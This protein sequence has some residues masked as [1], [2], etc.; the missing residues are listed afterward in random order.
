M[1]EINKKNLLICTKVY[2]WLNKVYNGRIQCTVKPLLKNVTATLKPSYNQIEHCNIKTPHYPSVKAFHSV[3]KKQ[4]VVDV[5]N[6]INPRNEL[7][8]QFLRLISLLLC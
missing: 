7:P 5:T 2:N 8:P 4:T 1:T 3:H 6:K